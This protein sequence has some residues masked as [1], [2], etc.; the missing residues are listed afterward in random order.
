[1]PDQQPSAAA[2]LNQPI[3]EEFRANGGS[4]GGMFQD[5][6][7]VLV[8]TA[9]RK[10]GKP[11]TNPVAYLRDGRRYLVFASNLGRPRHPGWYHNLLASPQAT[12]EIGTEDGRVKPLAARAVVLDGAERDRFYELQC[13][14]SPAFREYQ[15]RTTRKIPVVALYPLDLSENPERNRMIGEQLIAG[16]NALRAEL[17]RVRADIEALPGGNAAVLP[18]ANLAEQLRQHCLSYCYGLQ[19]HHI[20]EDGAFSAFEQHLP[21]L[22]PAISRLR[23][24][25]QRV[26][27]ALADLEALLSRGGTG[28]VALLR[29]EL[30]HVISGLEEHFTYEEEQLLP[31]LNEGQDAGR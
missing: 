21:H 17:R 9:G 15:E 27:Q 24:E 10:S 18:V 19:L 29:T 20:R 11:R 25:H 4:V 30:D 1:V 3:I 31:A 7:L 12:V 6:P 22:I 8:T 26:A 23:S 14:N 16:H 2:S 13:A 28:D 5:V